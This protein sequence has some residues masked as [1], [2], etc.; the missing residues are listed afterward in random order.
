MKNKTSEI[1]PL[2]Q[3][4]YAS[5]VSD[6]FDESD[7]DTL[8]QRWQRDN[9]SRD[10]TGVLLLRDRSFFQVIEGFTETVDRLF[11]R[12]A[13]DPRHV[14]VKVLSDQ[15]VDRRNFADWHIGFT[16]ENGVIDQLPG[17]VD[18]FE[19]KQT[20]SPEPALRFIDLQ[21]D[22]QRMRQILEGFRRGRWRRP[23]FSCHMPK[24]KKFHFQTSLNE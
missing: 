6:S 13:A 1:D 24:P 15:A 14:D 5:A 2:K 16:R 9:R 23:E 11:D 18:F 21:G 17:F 19:K 3:L 22:S 10:V 7:L 4:V 20:N 8:M 12:I